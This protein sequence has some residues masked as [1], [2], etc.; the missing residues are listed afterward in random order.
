MQRTMG[1]KEPDVGGAAGAG[2]IDPAG[3]LDHGSYGLPVHHRRRNPVFIIGHGSSGTTI[4]TKLLRKYLRISF[5]TESQF[6]HRYYRRLPLYGDLRRERNIRRLIRDILSERCFKRWRQVLGCTMDPEKVYLGLQSLSYRGVL[7]SI[8][9]RLAE[10]HQMTRWGDKTPEYVH[11]LPVLQELFPDAQYI[12]IVRDGRDVALSVFL[13]YFGA[14]N[15]YTAAREWRE[16][17]ELARSFLGGLDRSQYVDVRYEDL[18]SEPGEV[19]AKLIRFLDIEDRGGG[20]GLAIG[21]SVSL[22]LDS[23]NHGKW[24]RLFSE[25]QRLLYESVAGD[26]LDAYGYETIVKAPRKVRLARRAWFFMDDCLR[27]LS[28][29]GQV[30]DNLYRLKLRLASLKS[31]LHLKTIHRW[32]AG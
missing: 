13:R 29:P 22:E 25:S 19:F 9:L 5:G 28:H 26:L 21:R 18:L 4:M 1:Q 20:L 23:D 2:T 17:I 7:D 30:G 3:Q 27:R 14:K 15:I 31:Y 24:K 6:F 32:R 12:H 10:F 11:H 16:A 8:F